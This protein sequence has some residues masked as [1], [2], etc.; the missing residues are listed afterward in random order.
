MRLHQSD[1]DK[2]SGCLPKLKFFYILPFLCYPDSDVLLNWSRNI[3][4]VKESPVTWQ[5]TY[6][7]PLN[8]T[9]QVL[10]Q[11]QIISGVCHVPSHSH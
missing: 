6:L 1:L 3:V 2:S 7:I 5:D 10:N 11:L 9:T 8:Q 4:T